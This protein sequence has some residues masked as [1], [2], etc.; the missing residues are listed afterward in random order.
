[1]LRQGIAPNANRGHK[2]G[3]D[4][5]RRGTPRRVVEEVGTMVD[6]VERDANRAKFEDMH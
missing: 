3:G 5:G 2:K 1:M 6:G 4:E